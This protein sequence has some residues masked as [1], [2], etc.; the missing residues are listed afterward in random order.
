MEAASRTRSQP[1]GQRRQGIRITSERL[2]PLRPVLRRWL[3]SIPEFN[4][5][6]EQA[7]DQPDYPFWYGERASV[8]LLA[9][10]AWGDGVSLEEFTA[11]KGRRLGRADLWLLL[12]GEGFSIEAK[13]IWISIGSRAQQS[14][15]KAIDRELRAA[16]KEAR[17]LPTSRLWGHRL[18]AAFVVPW[19]PSSEREE[20]DIRVTRFLKEVI[21]QESQ[22]AWWFDTGVEPSVDDRCLYPGVVL[23][24]KSSR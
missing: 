5:Y 16:V 2:A 17:R 4:T 11:R 22:G 20:I 3:T 6:H 15:A 9:A 1:R 7:H 23:L 14:A 12:H 13:Q 24:F 21:D 10:A 8:G 19:L 18:G